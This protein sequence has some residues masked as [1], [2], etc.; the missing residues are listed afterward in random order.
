MSPRQSDFSLFP[1][2]KVDYTP[3]IHDHCM[4][5]IL[6][7]SL[8]G[9]INDFIAE[10]EVGGTVE[11]FLLSNFLRSITPLFE[12]ILIHMHYKMCPKSQVMDH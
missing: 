9:S 10:K 1:Y 8:G 4:A 5:L 11:K 6:G 2:L 12:H 7:D 3:S